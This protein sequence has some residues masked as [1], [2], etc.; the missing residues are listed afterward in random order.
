MFKI[1]I[2]FNKSNIKWVELLVQKINQK[3]PEVYL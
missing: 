3:Q 2:N 1:R